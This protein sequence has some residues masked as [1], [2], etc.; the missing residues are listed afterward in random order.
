MIANSTIIAM[1]ASSIILIGFLIGIFWILRKKVG[2]KF[3]PLAIG[4]VFFVI[5][6]LVLEQ[7]LHGVILQPNAQGQIPLMIN[8]PFVYIIY[9]IF[10]AGIFEETARLVAFIL[11]KK[12]YSN[13]SSGFAYGLGHGGMEALV[14]GGGSLLSN[15][16]ISLLLSDPNT[17]LAQELPQS[18]IQTLQNAPSS[19]FFLVVV[20]RIPALFVQ[21]CLSLLVWI[22]VNNSQKFWLFPLSILL[23]ALIDLPSAM[24]QVGFLTNVAVV[25][26]LLYVMAIALILFT[27]QVVKRNKLDPLKKVT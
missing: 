9:G 26:S 14:I 19:D 13:F 2:I 6:A 7:N 22:A 11:L 18:V 4:A 27:V 10:A 15:L 21:I 24:A 23:H 25:Y 3:V 16:V 1:A 8:H 17:E 12:S 20:E 5:F